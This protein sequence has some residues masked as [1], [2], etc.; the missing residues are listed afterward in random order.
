[1]EN[2]MNELKNLRDQIDKADD[3]LI[4]A[5]AKRMQLVKH[6]A[7][8]KEAAGISVLDSGRERNVL[9]RIAQKAEQAGLD[10]N[11]VETLLRSVISHSR[12][13]QH[14]ERESN[15]DQSISAPESFSFQGREGAYSWLAG[16]R[17]FGKSIYSRGYS[18]FS[19]ALDALEKGKVDRAVL[20]IQNTLA[21][22]IHDVYDLLHNSECSVIGENYLRVDHCLSAKELYSLDSI[23]VI[24]SHPVALRQCRNFIAN[25][26]Q[27]QFQAYSD[28]AEAASMVANA[29]KTNIAAIASAEAAE[30]YGLRVIGNDISDHPENYTRFWIIARE[31]IRLNSESPAITSLVI[32]TDHR[33]GALVT[34][35]KVIS[36]EGINMLKLESRG[37]PGVPWEHSFYID[38]EAAIDEPRLKS[39]LASL[40][41]CT[42]QIK[43]LGSYQRNGIL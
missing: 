3:E 34:C 1:V 12:A 22:S 37:K 18:T 36:D 2:D 16:K 42:L 43:I 31:P 24:Y 35:L 8:T 17:F 4:A 26:P 5:L 14:R 11:M 32:T 21:G 28:T 13:R 41:T 33:E 29:N 25:N 15:H 9:K 30:L 10:I 27:I 23:E 6:V 7:R 39:A 20:P 38:L 19:E 40:E